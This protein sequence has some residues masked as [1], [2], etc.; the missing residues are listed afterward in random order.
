MTFK[1]ASWDYVQD[2]V[3]AA[4]KWGDIGDWDVSGVKSFAWSFSVSRDQAGNY[5]YF[6][7]C[8]PKAATFGANLGLSDWDTSSVTC[9][10]WTFKGAANMN[11]DFGK[12][13]VSNV[14]NNG[15]VQ[16]AMRGMFKGAANF[17]GTGLDKWDTSKAGSMHTTFSGAS[18]MNSDLSGWDVS[19]VA[20]MGDMFDKATSL[21]SCNKRK[22]ANAWKGNIA[23]TYTSAWAGETCPVR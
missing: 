23:F 7:E 1:Q 15:G 22:I 9:M 14:N 8:N 5:C 19:K 20:D 21:D 18:A 2:T 13:D 3:A 17:Q 6:G 11:A 12:W 16:K 4:A 10:Y